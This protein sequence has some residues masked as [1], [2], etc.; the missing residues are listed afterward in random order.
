ME[1]DENCISAHIWGQTLSGKLWMTLNLKLATC[2]NNLG[3]LNKGG[4]A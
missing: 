4:E 1:R 2:T 3:D